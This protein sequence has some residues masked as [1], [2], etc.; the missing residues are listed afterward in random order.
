METIK[1]IAVVILVISV[2]LMTFLAILSIW[3]VLDKDVF[4]KSISTI[5]VVAFGSLIIV[6]AVKALEDRES[7]KKENNEKLTNVAKETL[8]NITNNRQI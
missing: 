7:N 3:D 6:V 4:W 2:T 5:G 1:K 8:G